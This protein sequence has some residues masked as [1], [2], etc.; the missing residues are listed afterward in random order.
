MIIKMLIIYQIIIEYLIHFPDVMFTKK[1]LNFKLKLVYV[2]NL[3]NCGSVGKVRYHIN[4]LRLAMQK[5][6]PWE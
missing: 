1:E 2:Y 6:T 3:T 5:N 4:Q